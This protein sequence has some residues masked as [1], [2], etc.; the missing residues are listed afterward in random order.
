MLDFHITN[1]AE[2]RK[3][4]RGFRNAD[5]DVL[6]RLGDPCGGDGLRLSH[7]SAQHE[8][9]RLKA[10]IHQIERLTGSIAVVCG[11]SVVTVHHGENARSNRY[12]RNGGKRYG[13]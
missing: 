13:N 2:T 4:Q 6:L 5:I 10:Q 3:Q 8:I 1:H 7:Q 11:D 12:R 9:A